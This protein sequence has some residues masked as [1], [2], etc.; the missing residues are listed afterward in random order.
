MSSGAR[1]EVS[2]S[3]GATSRWYSA[4]TMSAVCAA[5]VYG[6][7]ARTSMCSTTLASPCARA[8]HALAPLPGERPLRVGAP[9]KGELVALFG[10]GVADDEQFSWA[11]LL[12]VRGSVRPR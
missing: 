9:G 10:D 11:G 4:A 6:D 12:S 7:V 1:S 3:T 2:S 8:A 5:R